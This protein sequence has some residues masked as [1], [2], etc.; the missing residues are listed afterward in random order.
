VVAYVSAYGYTRSLGESIIEGI[1]MVGDFDT[2]LYDLV[3]TPVAEVLPH[4]DTASALILGSPTINGDA[5]PPIWQILTSLSPVVHGNKLAGAFGAFGWS[6]EAVPNIEYRLK[7]LR[8]DVV[9]GLKVNFKPTEADLEKAFAWGTDFSRKLADRLQPKA[10]TQWRCLICGQVFEGEEA[11]RVCPAC[12]ASQDN[13]VRVLA[14]DEFINDSN[15]TYVIIGGGIAALSAA[16]AIRKRNRQGIIK[17][18]SEEPVN[19]YYRTALSDY[20]SEDLS[21]S[22]LFIHDQAWY[23]DNKIELVTQARVTAVDTKAKSLTLAEG[24][25]VSYDKLIV[26][27][28]ARPNVPPLPGVD[29]VG[30]H[31]LRNLDDARAIKQHI[32]EAKRAVV[33]GG[34]VL[35]LEA[36][37]ELKNCGLEVAVVEF[38]P[39]IMPRQMD[40]DGS[41][42]LQQI[43][44][45][46]G[47]QLYLGVSTEEIQGNER[48]SGV[49]LS[50]GEVLPADL[51]IMSTGVKP[52]VEVAQAAGLDVKRGIVVDSM[53][54]TGAGGVYA[55]GDV[56]EINGVN[57][58]LWP[59]A[60]EQ[61]R[62]AGANAAGD[63]LEYTQPPLSTMLI[64]FNKE[65]FSVGDVNQPPG[66]CRVVQA[67]D[68]VE[69]AY[70]KYFMKD[71]TVL[72]AII[73]APKVKTAAAIR[74]VGKGGKVKATKWKC[75]RC[76]YIHEGPEPPEICPV[77]GA[78]KSFFDPIS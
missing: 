58:G 20:L 9:P 11:P 67:Y 42:R 16:E 44:T 33:I 31:P 45:E 47:V 35:G 30:V 24:S 10:K 34:G 7:A 54:R 26:A 18:Y 39:R 70:K 49:K 15:E 66:E 77:C 74:A 75:R 3:E 23:Q 5:L 62:V 53:M 65:I 78:P 38:M 57:I 22:E 29:K 61:G 51:V 32:N 14:E 37:W 13:F 43:I 27:T 69:D 60:I 8:M 6:G 28:G 59:I 19:V 4:I 12:G 40:E 17:I 68:P 76:G 72:G 36:A 73:I 1:S 48:V 25:Q 46:A 55:C 63:W 41:A 21:G 64:A 52:N 71:G 2:Q 50:S 56:A